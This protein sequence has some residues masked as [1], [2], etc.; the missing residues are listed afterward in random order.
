MTSPTFRTLD[1]A[2]ALTTGETARRLGVSITWIKTLINRGDLVAVRSSLGWLVDPD[3][4]A[5]Y[6]ARRNGREG[7]HV[8]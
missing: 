8:L 1:P 2:R 5:S 6:Q 4:V 3:S 7:S